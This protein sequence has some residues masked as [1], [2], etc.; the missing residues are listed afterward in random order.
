VRKCADLRLFWWFLNDRFLTLTK[1]YATPREPLSDGYEPQDLLDEVGLDELE[2]FFSETLIRL[3]AHAG[4]LPRKGI[5]RGRSSAQFHA[6]SQRFSEPAEVTR[7][8]LTGVGEAVTNSTGKVG[9]RI[10]HRSVPT[11]FRAD[12]IGALSPTPSYAREREGLVQIFVEGISEARA[13]ADELE[14]QF[15]VLGVDCLDPNGTFEV[16]PPELDP[17]RLTG[18]REERGQTSCVE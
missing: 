17:G 1:S 3:A 10:E 7:L 11:T 15:N 18:I 6:S 5:P 9:A 8:A 12:K 4:G 16:A 14:M 13:P 2:V